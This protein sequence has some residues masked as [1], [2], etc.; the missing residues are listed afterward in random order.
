[1]TDQYIPIPVAEY[2]E[3]R[4]EVE[5]L[6]SAV[7]WQK[8]SIEANVKENERLRVLPGVGVEEHLL[9][10]IQELRAENERLRAVADAARKMERWDRDAFGHRLWVEMAKALDALD[11]CQT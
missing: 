6:K 8:L 10:R 4:A 9:A 2:D 3:L 5:R 11:A 1:M 7:N